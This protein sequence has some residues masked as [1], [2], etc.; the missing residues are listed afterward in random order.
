GLSFYVDAG[1]NN[2]SNDDV[3]WTHNHQIWNQNHRATSPTWN[4]YRYD[5]RQLWEI[6]RGK[7]YVLKGNIFE[8]NWSFQNNGPSI[9]LSGRPTYTL[10]DLNVGIS[11]ILIRSNTIRH[12]SSGWTC[13]GGGIPP[14]SVTVQRVLFE[15]NFLHDINRYVYDDGGPSF[16]SSYMDALPG[17][18]DMTIRHNTMGLALGRAPWLMLIGGG[19]MLGGKLTYTDNIVYMSFGEAGGAIGVDDT[20]YVDSHPRLPAVVS[21]GTVKQKLDSYFVKLGATVQPNYS[22][23]NNV[24][25][26]GMTGTSMS[27]LRSLTSSE[28][29]SLASQFPPGN[30]FPVG[31]TIAEREQQ[32]GMV[33]PSESAYRLTENSPYRARGTNPSLSGKSIGAD[34]DQLSADQGRVLGINI[35][36]GSTALEV[37]YIAPD[38]RA[39]SVDTKPASGTDW[40]RVTD[41]GGARP[42]TLIVNALTPSTSYQYRILCYFPQLNDGG[43]ITGLGPDEITEGKISTTDLSNETVAYTITGATPDSLPQGPVLLQYG[44]GSDVSQQQG[45][46]PYNANGYEF[47]LQWLKGTALYY[48]IAYLDTANNPIGATTA[49][50]AV[51]VR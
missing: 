36:P 46:V 39:C 45:P 43:S 16:S 34:F 31:S 8:G 32:V 5:V 51:I 35:Q 47:T 4:G 14:D 21:N 19:S 25:I 27:T 11:D 18:Q 22:F 24:I 7:R 50:Q 12:A 41:P 13:A 2:Y 42:R 3:T 28:V 29:S 23:T 26:G 44:T 48:R 1:G 30:I 40:R 49:A 20:Q 9:F 38:G 10:A 37:N 17:C 33:N 6:K 15:N